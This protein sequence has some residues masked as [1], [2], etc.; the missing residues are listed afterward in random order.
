MRVINTERV[1]I[2]LWLEDIEDGAL[3]QAKNLAA[4]PFVHKWV[5]IMP[6]SHQ[7]YG[8]PIGGVLATE[9]VIIPNAVGVDIGCGMGAVQTSLSGIDTDTLKMIMGRVREAI[10]VGFNHHK[11]AQAWD[12]FDRAPDLPIIQQELSSARK[13]LGT[14][15]GGNH[16]IEFQADEGGAFWVM[17]HSGSRNFGLKAANV[18]HKQAQALCELWHVQLPDKDLAFLPIEEKAGHDYYAAMSF[19]LEFAQASRDHMMSAILRIVDDVAGGQEVRRV[20][21]HHNYAAMENHYGKNV[22]VHRKGATRVR[23][24][25]AGII[26][27][28]MGTAS[29][30]VEGLG[31][32]ESFHSCSHGA[33]RK[34]GR[35]QAERTLDLA[36]EQAKMDALGIV[37]GLRGK[38]GLD[39][40]P[41]AYKDIDTVMANQTDLVKITTRLRPL[42]SI[43]G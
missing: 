40:A 14:L 8:M 30:I 13:Q 11:E 36:E 42:G 18:Y 15:G 34:L 2:K 3:A 24:G 6:D 7:G 28:S 37:H 41:G 16:F 17:L 23:T 9:G 12:G 19:C 31:N 10:P 20:N 35:K 32:P 26:P 29:Y 5:A 21:I 38:G 27:G 4:L 33:G 25:E 39:E 22:W 43:K 1:P